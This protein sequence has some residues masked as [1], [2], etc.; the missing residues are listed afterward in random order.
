MDTTATRAPAE[1]IAEVV[2]DIRAGNTTS[3]INIP[4]RARQ[5]FIDEIRA[6]QP[7]VDCTAIHSTQ[8]RR[9]KIDLYGDH[10]EIVSPWDDAMFGFVNAF[11]NVII[12]QVRQSSHDG[13][14]F[15]Q[16]VWATDNAIEWSRVRWITTA[17]MWIGGR[18][19]HGPIATS[20]P[21]HLLRWAVCDSGEPADIGWTCLDPTLSEDQAVT[22][23]AALGFLNASNVGIAVPSRPRAVRRRMARTG[24]EVQAIVVRPPA[25]RRSSCGGGRPLDADETELTHVRGHF[26]RYGPRWGRGLLFG[27]LEGKFWVPGHVRGAEGSDDAGSNRGYVLKP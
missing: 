4:E 1:Q 11:G 22:L 5:Q 20:G 7:V 16:D 19:T 3:Q 10:N 13:S 8:L 14:A 27:R 18:G 6:Q 21:L 25:A 24:V 12:G 15:G 2:A 26:V 17:T 23:T 9:S